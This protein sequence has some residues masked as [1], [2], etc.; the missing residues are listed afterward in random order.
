[1]STPETPGEIPV[2]RKPQWPG[3]VGGMVTIVIVSRLFM[4]V[5]WPIA[6]IG[7]VAG[8]L[9]GALSVRARGQRLF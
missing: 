8:A 7:A 9:I 4:H 3:V 6:A 2:P 5:S 1:M